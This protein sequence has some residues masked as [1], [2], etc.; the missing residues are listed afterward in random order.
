MAQSMAV[1]ARAD[2][3]LADDWLIGGSV[4]TS[5]SGVNRSIGSYKEPAQVTLAEVHTR[6]ASGPWTARAQY[7]QGML[8][9]AAGVTR[10]NQQTY[11]GG[12][13]GV[14][15]TQIGAEAWGAFVEAGYNLLA[16]G[17][18]GAD[19]R[20]DL[21]ARLDRF[22]SMSAV[23]AGQNDILRYDRQI[24]TGGVN[25]QLH[26]GVVFKGEVAQ[27]TNQSNVANESLYAALG[28]GVEF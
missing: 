13:L 8:D 24:I 3:Q 14:S 12:E 1:V 27:E 18:A 16:G 23:D 28:V 26:P 20:L 15:R 4:Y 11:N 5:D 21:F 19:R 9:N 6:F 10:A 25:F 2:W 7:L 17:E 22:D